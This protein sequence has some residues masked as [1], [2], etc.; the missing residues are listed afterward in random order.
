MEHLKDLIKK[1]DFG[2]IDGLYDPNLVKNYLDFGF[3]DSI[4]NG[5]IFFVL[6]RKGTGKS[7]LY[8]Y[9][10][11]IQGD[12]GIL[13]S[14]LSFKNFPFEK[15][16]E[17]TDDNFSKPNQ[18]Q[19]IWRNIILSEYAKLIITDQSN[20]VEEIFNEL[21]Q[22]VDYVF[23]TD[24]ID[25][26]K[27][28]T[29]SAE[30]KGREIGFAKRVFNIRGNR[31]SSSEKELT[32]SFENISR[33]NERLEMLIISYLKLNGTTQYIVQFDQLDDNYNVYIDN[34][35]YFQSLIS[36]FKTVYDLNQTFRSQRIKAKTVAYLRSD[37]FYAVNAFDAES[38]RWDQFKMSLNWAIINRSDWLKPKLRAII[39]RRI[40]NSINIKGEP[41]SIVF[42]SDKLG[43][44]EN[45]R[46]IKPF[47]YIV[48][49]SFHRPRDIIQFCIK[50][51]QQV[52]ETSSYY[53][54]TV[55]NA[56][57]EYSL[58]LLSE[59]ENEIAP[60]IKN[61]EA[62]YELLRLMGRNF[63]SMSDFKSRFAKFSKDID[64][65]TEELLKFL[66]SL[67]IIFNVNP[68]KDMTEIYSIIR[69][70]RSVFNRDIMI[71]T[72][73]GFYNG[74]YT[75]KFMKR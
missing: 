5:N 69:N 22:Y 7:A 18:Y 59:L 21:K 58:W 20:P 27:K 33:I 44:K 35:P 13:V 65:D 56:E 31:E 71:K 60:R 2:D 40:S 53:H 45:G 47:K 1:I 6:G 17:L 29:K 8:N 67:G 30:K 39:N 49:R 38:A 15:L 28:V 63:Y 12:K 16:L 50:I 51:Q 3:S 14:N 9:V 57:K 66:Y 68:R 10:N 19:S 64:M 24:L 54:T 72:H 34:Q 37:I 43:L 26:H 75:S 23:G 36:L 42:N 74:L 70:D 52:K 32:E 11:S 46:L 55:L 61:T 41:F 25:L 62:L 4:I 73:P 48:H